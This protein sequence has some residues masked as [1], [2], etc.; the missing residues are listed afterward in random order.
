[1]PLRAPWY[2]LALL[3]AFAPAGHAGAMR[4][5][6]EPEAAAV[7][8]PAPPA[9]VDPAPRASDDALV[10]ENAPGGGVMVDV[11]G[12]LKSEVTGSVAQDGSVRTECRA[13]GDP[14]PR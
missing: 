13:P 11:R 12:R 6:V 14:T 7:P 10:E 3:L 5:E 4:A 9:P 2:A 1:V 8:A